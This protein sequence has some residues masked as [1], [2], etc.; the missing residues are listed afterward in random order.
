M[1]ELSYLAKLVYS[2]NPMHVEL[3]SG[4]ATTS[5][6]SITFN[7]GGFSG[8]DYVVFCQPTADGVGGIYVSSKTATGFTATAETA[9]GAFD[10]IAIGIRK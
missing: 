2:K 10:F 1:S 6:A 3:G 9:D 7:E 8:T 4:T 5:G